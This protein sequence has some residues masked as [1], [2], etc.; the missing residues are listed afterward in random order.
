ME[1]YNMFF[2]LTDMILSQ[3]MEPEALPYFP[4]LILQIKGFFGWKVHGQRLGNAACGR[5]EI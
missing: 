2:I 3:K 4:F 1:R 5:G